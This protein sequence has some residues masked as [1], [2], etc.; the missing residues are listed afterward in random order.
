[1]LVSQNLYPADNKKVDT[2]ATHIKEALNTREIFAPTKTPLSPAL[3]TNH[4]LTEAELQ[5]LE[6]NIITAATAGTAGASVAAAA[7]A[8]AT[9]AV[10]MKTGDGDDDDEGNFSYAVG[11]SIRPVGRPSV[12]AVP[13]REDEEDLELRKNGGGGDAGD[14]QDP[15]GERRGDAIP[16]VSAVP[17]SATAT[18]ITASGDPAVGNMVQSN[19]NKVRQFHPACAAAAQL[20]VKLAMSTL[21]HTFYRNIEV[22]S[23]LWDGSGTCK[24]QLLRSIGKWSTGTKEEVSIQNCYIDSINNAKHF[25]YIENQ[26]F[27]SSTAGSDVSNGIAAA[28]VNRICAAHTA[29][30]AF[31][32]VIIVPV[33]PNGD[34]AS[35]KKAQVVMHYEYATI[36][37]GIGSM[38]AQLRRRAPS[39]TISN[40]I[41]FYSLRNWGVINNK[42]VSDQVYVHDKVMIVDDRVV[43]IGSANINDRSLLGERDSELA[44]R[45]EDT[46][47]CTVPMN[48]QPFVVGFMPHSLRVRLMRQHLGETLEYGT[49]S[50]LCMALTS[51]TMLRFHIFLFFFFSLF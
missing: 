30:E 29:G 38:F 23:R 20:E 19:A 8:P 46:L 45:I 1:M 4:V 26:F 5:E 37:R 40:Y 47:H 15:S 2:D 41:G 25:I 10:E 33:H 27:V 39:I 42:V 28:L 32:V 43:I 11:A 48:D 50:V 14:G 31:R 44:I 24:V 9:S 12:A 21:F 18:A 51:T 3:T 49:Y 34:F 7:P 22:P 17:F 35:A 36:N 6:R 16:T 13:I